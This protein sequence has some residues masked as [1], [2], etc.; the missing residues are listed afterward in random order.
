M[1]DLTKLTPEE[2]I[3]DKW[4]IAH[5]PLWDEIRRRLE[6]LE[7]CEAAASR[8]INAP[9]WDSGLMQQA[10]DALAKALEK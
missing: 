2:L 10:I 5:G 4:R 3:L 1:T 7:Q 8:I 6:R 9:V